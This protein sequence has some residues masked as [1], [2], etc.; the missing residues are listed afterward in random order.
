M[1]QKIYSVQVIIVQNVMLS[2][3]LP[4]K[5]SGLILMKTVIIVMVMDI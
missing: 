5:I 3:C 1:Y 4:V 2:Y